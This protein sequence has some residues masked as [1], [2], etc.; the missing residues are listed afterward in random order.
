MVPGAAS[1][2][3][4]RQQLLGALRARPDSAAG[5]ARRLGVPR[6]RVNYHLR[7]LERDGLLELHATRRRRGLAERILRV[8]DAAADRFSSLYLVALAAQLLGDVSALRAAA[9][10]A[11][12]KLAT[13]ALEVDVRFRSAADRAAF[14]EQLTA[15]VAGLAARYHDASAPAGRTHRFVVAGHPARSPRSDHA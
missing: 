4:L 7:A 10:R 6:Q 8:P 3:P 1:L 5:L 12:K 2:S 13:F 15:A 9:E 14:G 11:R